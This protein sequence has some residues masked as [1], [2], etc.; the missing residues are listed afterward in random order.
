MAALAFADVLLPDTLKRLEACL[1]HIR[2]RGPMDKVYAVV[3]Q[4]GGAGKTTTVISLGAVWAAWGLRVRAIDADPQ[5]GSATFWLP[6]QRK[7]PDLKAVY[8]DEATLDEATAETAVPGLYLVPSDKTLGQ[9]EYANLPDANLSMRSAIAESAKYDV[10]LLDCRPTLGVL[11]VSQLV[12]APEVIIPLG[13][14]GMD[15]P[16]LV[17]LADTLATVR[18]RL[19]PALRV[20]AVV[21]CD[22]ADT[23]LSR[24][25]RAQLEE[26]YPDA[27]HWRIRHSVRVAEA[28]FAHKPLTEYAPDAPPTREY[29][30]LAAELL[31]RQG[32]SA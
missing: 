20:T 17:E 5:A 12:A 10:T 16:G 11:T 18:R 3:N 9:V 30:G 25:V 28:P 26:D 15:V 4:K 8:F 13:A 7:A 27:V 23:L 6:P 22:D 2:D 29:I 19:N 24:D 31:I 32:V 21:V 1:D 14:S